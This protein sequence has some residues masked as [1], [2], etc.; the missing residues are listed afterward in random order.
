MKSNKDVIQELVDI[1]FDK[2]NGES[3]GSK[4]MFMPALN[5]VKLKLSNLNENESAN[6][7]DSVHK[8]SHYCEKETG[9]L[10]PYHGIDD[11]IN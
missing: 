10:S 4:L 11:N 3:G 6:I 1:V 9:N 5:V 2:L 8:I 7:I